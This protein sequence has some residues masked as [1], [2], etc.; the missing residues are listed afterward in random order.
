[1]ALL[2][3]GLGFINENNSRT[4]TTNK[5]A[6]VMMTQSINFS[7]IALKK[8]FSPGACTMII[9]PMSIITAIVMNPSQ[10]FRLNI[11]LPPV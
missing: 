10:C 4:K 1:M 9:C 7:G 8:E 3:F 2:R 5:D 11:P 6:P